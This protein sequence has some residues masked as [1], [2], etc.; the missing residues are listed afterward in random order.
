[1][2]NEAV[3]MAVEALDQELTSI[4]VGGHQTSLLLGKARRLVS[5]LRAQVTKEG[6]K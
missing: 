3:R 6:G 2:E 5:E 4:S 1:M